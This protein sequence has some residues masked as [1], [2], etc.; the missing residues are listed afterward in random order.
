MPVAH[1]NIGSNL[2][3]SRSLIERAAAGIALLSEGSVR[4]SAFVESDAWGFDSPHR[5]VNMGME[6]ET[7]LHPPELLHR[8]LDIQNGISDGPHRMPDGAY[9]DRLIDI[10]LIFVDDEVVDDDEELTLPH[11]RMHLRPFVLKPLME[12]SPDWVHPLT[13]RTAAGMLQLLAEQGA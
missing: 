9:V 4:R 12:L 2:G 7:S 11:P 3:D 10:D 8:L 5:F 6:I 1:I 13:G